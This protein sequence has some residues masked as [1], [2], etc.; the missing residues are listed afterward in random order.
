M[1]LLLLQKVNKPD[2]SSTGY[3]LSPVRE[4]LWKTVVRMKCE[5]GPEIETR[6]DVTVF[7]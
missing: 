4:G 1:H 7:T 2:L 3:S 6:R 5:G